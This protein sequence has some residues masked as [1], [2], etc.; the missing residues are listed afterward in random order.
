[1]LRRIDAGVASPLVLIPLAHQRDEARWRAF[2]AQCD[3][4]R[5]TVP[6]CRVL[7]E[8]AEVCAILGCREGRWR[9]PPPAEDGQRAQTQ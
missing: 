7:F 3:D 6:Q 1:M 9:S 5:F 4:A 8:T 2:A